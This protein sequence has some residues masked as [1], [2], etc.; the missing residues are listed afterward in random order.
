MTRIVT[1][2]YRR[3]PK[4]RKAVALDVLAVVMKSSRRRR[5]SEQA[6]AEVQEEMS[7]RSENEAGTEPVSRQR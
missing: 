7:P 6:A 5:S 4:K 2:S 1:T 3:L